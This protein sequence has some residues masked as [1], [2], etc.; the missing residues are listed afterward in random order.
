MIG[1]VTT[2]PMAPSEVI[3]MVE[4]L[5]AP[6]ASR[7]R[8]CAASASR[9]DLGG[10]VPQIERLDVPDHRHQQPGGRLRRDADMDAG[11]LVNDARLVV[12]QRV[13]PRLLAIAGTIAR[14]R[15]GSSVSLGCSLPL[16][17]GSASSRSSSSAVTSTSS[18]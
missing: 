15:N 12:E 7:C 14:I 13:Q 6:R 16:S 4:P 5:T 11:M 8:C 10:A 1:V 2:P 17:A 3:V 18:T 9:R